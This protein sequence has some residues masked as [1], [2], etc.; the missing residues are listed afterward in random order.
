MMA[1][2]RVDAGVAVDVAIVLRRHAGEPI[3]ETGGR[4]YRRA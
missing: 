2:L 4:R 1:A 3:S